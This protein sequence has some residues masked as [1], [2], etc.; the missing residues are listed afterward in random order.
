MFGFDTE[1][2]P[3]D[4]VMLVLG[5]IMS[6]MLTVSSYA[7]FNSEPSFEQGLRGVEGVLI[8]P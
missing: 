4:T 7:E 8:Q 6:L 5:N 1:F 3:K 2:S